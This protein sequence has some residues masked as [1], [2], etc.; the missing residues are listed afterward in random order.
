MVSHTIES[1]PRYKGIER[2]RKRLG[3]LLLYLKILIVDTVISI[4][5]RGATQ[6]DLVLLIRMDA[7]GDFIVWLDAARAIVKH[8]RNQDKRVVLL[9]NV[10]WADWARDLNLFDS[11]IAIDRK[12]FLQ[13]LS[14]RWRIGL[15]VRKLACATAIY[16]SYSREWLLGD[17]LVRISGA[18]ERIGSSGDNYHSTRWQQRIANLWYTRLVSADSAPQMELKRN[19]EFVRNLCDA[20]F[21]AK[22]LDLRAITTLALDARWRVAIPQEESYYVMFPGAGWSG[23]RWPI[24]NFAQIAQKLYVKTGWHG[25]ICGGDEDRSIGEELCKQSSAPLLNCCGETHLTQLA[26][27]VASAKLL[28]ANE[29]SAMH[30]AAACGV[31]TVCILGGGDY[32]R[33]LPYEV[34]RPSSTALPYPVTFPMS[35]FGCRWQCIYHRLDSEPT[36]CIGQISITTVWEIVDKIVGHGAM[37]IR[38]D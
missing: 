25:V 4:T 18:R 23:R 22:V 35:C 24:G 30:I 19:A 20:N 3:Y 14:Y 26:A 12:G 6:H 37:T 28:V 33:F 31:P 34:E 16:P 29:T 38:L 11:V 7:I 1:L 2:A 13:S 32:G 8:Y 27:I 15:Q 17:A 5:N 9:G 21:T 10:T 36:P